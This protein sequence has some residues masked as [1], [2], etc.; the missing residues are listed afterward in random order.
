[1]ADIVSSRE[2]QVSQWLALAPKVPELAQGQWHV[3]LSYRSVNRKWVLHLYDALRTAGFAVFVDQLEIAAGDSL[4]QRLNN[5]LSSSQSGVIVWSTHYD[6]SKWCQ[7]EYETM[8]AL[9][10]EGKFRFVVVKLSASVAL[11]PLVK[12]DV[13]VDFSD[14]PDGPQGGELLKL[15]YGVLSQPLPAAVLLAAQEI[16]EQ[17]KQSLSGIRGAK[18]AENVKKLMKDAAAGGSAQRRWA[19]GE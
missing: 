2:S 14:Y 17:T 13:Y 5:A 15:M 10:K 11:P 3:F 8:E 16:D 9:R 1:M 6:D 12:K 19:F 4:A 7:S 18:A